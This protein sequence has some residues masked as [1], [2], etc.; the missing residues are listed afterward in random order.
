MR[1]FKP[2]GRSLR[3]S[4]LLVGALCLGLVVTATGPAAADSDIINASGGQCQGQWLSADNQFRIRDADNDDSDYCYVDYSWNSAHTER[5]RVSRPQDINTNWGYY[6]VTV[7]AQV[8]YFHVCKERQD[9][10]DVCSRWVS[11]TT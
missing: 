8:I 9:D 4:G 7:T 5:S 10:P 6:D 1:N 11:A 3:R 2:S